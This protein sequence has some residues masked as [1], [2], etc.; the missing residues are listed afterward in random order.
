MK[1]NCANILLGHSVRHNA[2]RLRLSVQFLIFLC[3]RQ[4]IFAGMAF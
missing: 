1:H 4:F 2:A 3:S